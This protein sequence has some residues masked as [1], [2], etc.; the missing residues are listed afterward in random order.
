M[1]FLDPQANPV[2]LASGDQG[3][4]PLVPNLPS[5]VKSFQRRYNPTAVA[6]MRQQFHPDV[7]NSFL[8]F[9]RNR[10]LN[11]QSPL[12]PDVA[13]QA[14]Q[15]AQTHKA[16]TPP[17]ERDPGDV[18]GNI[19]SDV[20]N[21]VT[22]IPKMP[23]Q[24]AHD[25]MHAPDAAQ[26]LSSGDPSTILQ[27]PLV[28]L[29]PGTYTANNLITGNFNEI[30]SH[31]VMT[32]LDVLPYWQKLGLTAKLG[33]IPT[34]GDATLGERFQRV[35]D[36][37]GRTKLGQLTQEAW[38]PQVRDASRI[39]AEQPNLISQ[40]M[41]PAMKNI[42]D[43]TEQHL[44]QNATSI[45][46]EFNQ[47]V[48]D[49]ERQA[50]LMHGLETDSLDQ[51]GASD[52][53][54]AALD[55]MVGG[56]N[57]FEQYA[58]DSS[59]LAQRTIDGTTETFTP[60]QAAKLDKARGQF[61]RRQT[62]TTLRDTILD[63]TTADFD[64]LHGQVTEQ[65]ARPDLT[66][67]QRIEI[68]TGY[69]H[70]LDAAG[71]DTGSMLHDLGA[72]NKGGIADVMAERPTAMLDE[73]TLRTRRLT[74]QPAMD[75]QTRWL[76][77]HRTFTAKKLAGQERATRAVETRTLPARWQPLFQDIKMD[78]A[79]NYVEQ[80]I[81]P[82]DPSLPGLLE[83]VNGH[84][85]E[86]LGK[87]AVKQLN[88]EVFQTIA[89]L[90]QQ[91]VNPQFVHH[92]SEDQA[93]M[94][95]SPSV[96]TIV[97]KPSQ[98]AARINDW[99]PHSNSLS[100]S[101][102]HQGLELLRQKGARAALDALDA[103]HT[104]TYAD[105]MNE[106]RPAAERVAART[107]NTVAVEMERLARKSYVRWSDTENGFMA[108]SAKPFKITEGQFHPDE[109][110]IPRPIANS[111]NML[112]KPP[113]Y[114]TI[115]D[116]ILKVF[117]T[118]VLPF[119][120]RFHINN[121]A[122]GAIFGALEDPRIFAKGQEGFKLAKA[123]SD[124]GKAI[125]SQA[126][127]TLSPDVEE[128]IKAMPDSMKAQ[129]GSFKYSITPDHD[130]RLKAGAK[131]GE[132]AQ[133]AGVD[134]MMKAGGRAIDWSFQQNELMDNMYRA[135]G[136]LSEHDNALKAGLSPEEAGARGM[137]LA[138]KFQPRWLEMTP[139]ER[140]VFRVAFPFYAFMSHVFRY[141]MRYP[142]DHPWRTAVM[143]NMARAELQDFGTGL[144]QAL[145]SAFFLGSPD[146]EGNQ[147][148][149]DIGAANPFRDLGDQL[150]VAGFLGQTN[151][152]FKTALRQMGYDPQTRGP[153]LYPEVTYD[154]KT[155]R[156]MAQ[157]PNTLGTL[158]GLVTDFVPQANILA[159]LTGTSG[160]FKQLLAS[161]PEAAQR[162]LISSAGIP[163]LWKSVNVPEQAFKAE[164][165]RSNQEKLVLSR[166]MKTGDYS[167][168]MKWPHLQ[169]IISQLQ[170]L[171]SQQKLLP[172][173]A[174]QGSKA[175]T[176]AEVKNG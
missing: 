31:P 159:A 27:A 151:P 68:A 173:Q 135:M 145:A 11:G 2:G 15:T 65:L 121:I 131:L 125:D 176:Q 94:M 113:R 28:R 38:S 120:P 136:Y 118:S 21:L 39:M 26:A 88:S 106:L 63:P 104:R 36:S 97:P 142:I 95:H 74:G 41:H 14:L 3:L 56:I 7:V 152:I 42:F 172:Y 37:L 150:T 8:K 35:T 162:M 55:R 81:S 92:V 34:P 84:I 19:A 99:T 168:A 80:T 155:G 32:A 124:L 10:A 160:N 132:F 30:L 23:S 134:R 60:Q 40:Q 76:E 98:W 54:R 143:A 157:N 114:S 4:P 141:A 24:I 170:Q 144:P 167:Q 140:S 109:K 9:E 138:N 73:G 78:K 105:V 1:S 17:P 50:Q 146:K 130:F 133:K 83:Q 108:G 101:I 71:Y 137:A 72:T 70:A 79:R 16:A 175:L 112:A 22:S 58:I 161:N 77:A 103:A 127:Y 18:L 163:V 52:A 107:G 45:A 154:P 33:E 67:S 66:K 57:Q 29:I 13:V 6:Q 158:G 128:I 62:I 59:Q 93:R 49:P 75:A 156:L 91:G 20:G 96:T 111:L 115:F 85:Y 53:E 100:V 86:G 165:T 102:T 25:V 153:N 148:V 166:A 169:P 61:S 129:M 87:D 147:N 149:I 171:Q 89:E 82:D 90:R 126:D 51:L 110:L 12:N 122:G 116:P 44:A 164:V 48:P 119:S 64:A 117:R 43:S 174:D 47:T 46:H 139:M 69:V 123:Y 5:A